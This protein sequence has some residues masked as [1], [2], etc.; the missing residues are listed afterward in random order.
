MLLAN[1]KTPPQ[2]LTAGGVRSESVEPNRTLSITDDAKISK[3]LE[4][5][6]AWREA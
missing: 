4:G 6:G 2:M 5:N 1:E 3:L